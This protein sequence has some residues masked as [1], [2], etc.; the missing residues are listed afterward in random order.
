MSLVPAER[1]ALAGIED[2]LCHSDPEL[3][4]MLARFRVPIARG[5]LRVLVRRL[6]RPG[7]ILPLIV[8]I[9]LFLLVLAMVLSPAAPLPCDQHGG[10]RFAASVQVS[11]CPPAHHQGRAG[12]GAPSSARGQ[13]GAVSP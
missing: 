11:G 8:V 5:G 2:A 13:T 4:R 7:S 6:L 1:R 3:A 12:G 9:A 10:T